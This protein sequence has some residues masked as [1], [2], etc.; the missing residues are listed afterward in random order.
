MFRAVWHGH[1]SPTAIAP[2]RWRP[3]TTSR[4]S[5][6]AG[7]TSPPA[8]RRAPARG[9]ARRGTTTSPGRDRKCQAGPEAAWPAGSSGGYSG[10]G[11]DRDIGSRDTGQRA[12]VLAARMPVLHDAAAGAA[13]CP[14]ARRVDQHL[15]R[16]GRRGGSPG[17]H[18]RGRDRSHGRRRYP[19]HGELL[20]PAGHL[21]RARRTARRPP[22]AGNPA[23]IAARAGGRFPHPPQA[24]AGARR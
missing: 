1:S 13:P 23:R 6:C 10:R 9:R 21:S 14:G 2:S 4:R 16:P 19:G 24:A 22:G 15:G 7:S 11:R 12:G 20:S 3:T 8:L 18:W 5:R 17:H